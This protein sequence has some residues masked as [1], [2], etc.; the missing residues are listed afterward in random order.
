MVLILLRK[1][2]RVET[3]N[4]E[5]LTFLDGINLAEHLMIELIEKQKEA[6][7]KAT[8]EKLEYIVLDMFGAIQEDYRS[9]RIEDMED[10]FNIESNTE[11]RYLREPKPPIV[12]VTE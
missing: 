10:Y 11:F 4:F 2:E 12:K 5:N 3:M 8:L 1:H 7:E 6:Q 9:D